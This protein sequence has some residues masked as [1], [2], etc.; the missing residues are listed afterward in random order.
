[1]EN[2]KF[3]MDINS[4]FEDE[5]ETIKVEIAVKTKEFDP[6]NITLDENGEPDELMT[7]GIIFCAMNSMLRG[8]KANDL[9]RDDQ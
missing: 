6:N 2:G 4:R 7:G 9:Q 3:I 1:M 5:G 8:D